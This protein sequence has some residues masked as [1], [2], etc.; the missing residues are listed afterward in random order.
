MDTANNNTNTETQEATMSNT[1]TRIEDTQ[2]NIRNLDG[3]DG[4]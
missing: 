3:P 1:N 4:R 2:A